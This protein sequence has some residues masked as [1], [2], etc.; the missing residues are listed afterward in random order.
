M[1]DLVIVRI[2]TNA[3]SVRA[4]IP[5][6]LDLVTCTGRRL[7]ALNAVPRQV[8]SGLDPNRGEIVNQLFKRLFSKFF[9]FS[10]ACAAESTNVELNSVFGE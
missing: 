3:L 6:R 7:A 9:S 8:R 2:I 10:G 5:S 4:E 1:Q